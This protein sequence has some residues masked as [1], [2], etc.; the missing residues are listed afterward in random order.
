MEHEKEEEA[1]NNETSA[2]TTTHSFRKVEFEIYE[3]YGSD[4]HIDY[5]TPGAKINGGL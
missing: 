4:T 3:A 2:F 1:I 5:N